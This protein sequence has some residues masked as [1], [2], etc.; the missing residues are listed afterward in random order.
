M[1]FDP[2]STDGLN[3]CTYGWVYLNTGTTQVLPPTQAQ[4]MCKVTTRDMC[5]VTT[6]DM[7][8][9]IIQD[10]YKVIIRG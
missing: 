9:A 7:C 1:C 5:K 8:K 3:P 6:Q 2:I 10:M 4:D